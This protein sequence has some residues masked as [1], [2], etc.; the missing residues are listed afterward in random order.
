M[1]VSFEC[2]VCIVDLDDCDTKIRAG[3]E[4]LPTLLKTSGLTLIAV[5][6]RQPRCRDRSTTLE[7]NHR[8]KV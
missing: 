3:Q 2:Y 1:G 4:D 7:V 6:P 5:W 8:D